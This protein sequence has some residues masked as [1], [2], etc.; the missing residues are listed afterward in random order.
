MCGIAGLFSKSSPIEEKLG[1][2]LSAMLAELAERGPDSAGVALYRDPAP[3]GSCKVSLFSPARRLSVARAGGE[4][5]EAF[6]AEASPEVRHPRP[7]RRRGRG[8]ARSSAGSRDAH[9]ELRVMSVGERIEI[10]KEAVDPREFIKRFGL[11][12]RLGDA[13][14][15][16]HPDGDR[17]PGHHRALP[18][19]L[20]R[21]STSAWSTTARSPTTT[22][23]APSL[24]RQGNRVP[25]RQRLRGRRR[26]PDLAAVRG[27]RPRDRAERLPRP[28]STASTPSPS[29]PPTGS[30]C[31]ATRSPAS[32]R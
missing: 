1:A 16:A 22:G 27:R 11:G 17:E 23:C 8:A 9:P 7:V 3:A 14:A 2:H 10:Y 20:D 19:V 21:A 6:G 32:R 15:R 5:A 18:P 28:T 12:D 30:P 13:R 31:S 24:R 4:L 25:D 26:L 29:A